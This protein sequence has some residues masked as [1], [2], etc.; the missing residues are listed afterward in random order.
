MSIQNARALYTKLLVDEE[1]RKQLEQAA[2]YQKRYGILE[3]AG[4]SCTPAELKLAK[5]ELLQSLKTNE[6]LSEI[7]QEHIRGGSSIQ[8]L[9]NH[10]DDYLFKEK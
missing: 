1:F 7:E 3:T 9:L 8:F 4:F 5:N 10:F 6:E 2:S